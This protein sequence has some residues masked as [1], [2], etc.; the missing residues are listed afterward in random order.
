MRISKLQ[1]LDPKYWDG[2][3]SYWGFDSDFNDSFV[4]SE[5]TIIGIF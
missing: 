3:V 2:L 1:T 5:E 4:S